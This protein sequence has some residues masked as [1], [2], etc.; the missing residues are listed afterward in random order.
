MVEGSAIGYES[1]AANWQRRIFSVLG[2][3]TQYQLDHCCQPRLTSVRGARSFLRNTSKTILS[4]A[5]YRQA[6]SVLLITSATGRRNRLYLER[7]GDA[8][9]DVSH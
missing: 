7:T 5:K 3:H 6:C 4:Y 2:A 1:N 9:F 8:V